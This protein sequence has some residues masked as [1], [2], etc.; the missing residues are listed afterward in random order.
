MVWLLTG[1]AVTAF[2]LVVI[3][4]APYVPSHPRAVSRAFDNLHPISRKDLVVDLGSGD[5]LVLRQAAQ[6]GARAIGYELNIFLV[7][8]SWLLSFKR[9]SRIKV[10]WQNFQ[11]VQLPAK[12]TLVYV[13]SSS[14][15]IAGVASY[16]ER[17]ARRLGRSFHVISYGFELPGR[18]PINTYQAHN[19]YS[20][21]PLQD[22]NVNL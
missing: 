9:R 3:F 22:K 5:G 19:L 12:T 11:Q 18:R 13:F 2:G 6:K 7:I 10:Y 14:K 8:I 21:N 16:L 17:E 4:G 15:H 1:V 20:I